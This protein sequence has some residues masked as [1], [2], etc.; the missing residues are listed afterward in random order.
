MPTSW[1]RPLYCRDLTRADRWLALAL[2]LVLGSANALAVALPVAAAPPSLPQVLYAGSASEPTITPAQAREVVS[3]WWPLRLDALATDDLTLAHALEG[4]PAMQH[5][6]FVSRSNRGYAAAGQPTQPG[7]RMALSPI[8]TLSVAVPRQGSLPAQFLAMVTTTTGATSGAPGTVLQDLLVFARPRVEEPWRAMFEIAYQGSPLSP[9]L[10]PDSGPP[11]DRF[12]VPARRPS[13]LDPAKIPGLLAAYWQSWRDTGH[14]PASSPFADGVDTTQRGQLLAGEHSRIRGFGIEDHE[15][16]AVDS[17]DAVWQFS[18]IF[19]SN[20]YCFTIRGTDD[21]RP[22]SPG[23]L[24]RQPASRLSYGGA[25]PPGLYSRIVTERAWET[26]ALIPTTNEPSGYTGPIPPGIIELI[27]DP[28]DEDVAMTGSPARSITPWIVAILGLWGTGSVTA[29]V[30]LVWLAALAR[31]RP[32][33]A[34][35]SAR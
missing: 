12:A 27:G 11:A 21:E 28:G 6:D 13:W 17:N 24:L 32:T 7:V 19:V 26:C 25:L 34:L 35:T 5:D 10:V 2:A 33:S 16:F 3:A 15:R 29:V 30:V 31:R 1:R 20:L 18:A 14:P 23:G 8:Q 4:G 9:L 22:S